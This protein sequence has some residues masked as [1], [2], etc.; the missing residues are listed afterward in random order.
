MEMWA[1]RVPLSPFA[2]VRRVGACLLV[3]SA[4]LAA[5]TS[6][7][8]GSAGLAGSNHRI[9]VRTDQV[10]QAFD[11]RLLG[12]NVP[13]WLLPQL[14]EDE[15]FRELVVASGTTM[16]RLPGGS[17]SNHYDWL[18]CELG[19]PQRC[20]WTWALRP[21][22]FLELLET[23]GL[24]AMWTVSINGTAEEAAAAVAFFNGTVDDDRPIGRDRNGRDWLTV[25]HWAQL[26]TDGGHPEPAPIQF[27]EVGNEV[28]GA[29]RTAGRGCASWGWE[30]VW[31]CDGA[32]YVNGTDGHDG[33]LQFREEMRAVDADIEV[34][35]VGVGDLGAW[36][37]WDNKVM[38]GAADNIDFYVVHQYG[39]N[40]DVPAEDVFGIP[41]REWP[42]ITGDIRDAYTDYGIAADV[43]IAATEHNLVAFLDGDDEQLMTRAVNA[44]YLAETIGQMA[45]SGVTIANQW[46]LANGRGANGTDYGLIDAQTHERSPAYYAMALWSRFGDELVGVDSDPG[47]NGLGLYGGRS[48]D[49][50]TQLLV[51]NPSATGFG[52]TIAVEPAAAPKVVTADVVV[53]DSLLATSVSWNGSPTPSIDLSELSKRLP[54]T[55][56]GELRHDFP[57]YSITL[58]SWGAQAES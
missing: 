20:Y 39:S 52:A 27:W 47:L 51:V 37:D 34:G 33:F 46:N 5:C 11:R 30:D 54:V 48:P 2:S 29:V 22:D 58:L 18:G 38:G 8:L 53:A 6:Q 35:A 24:P 9:V 55:A 45:T 41:R 4:L 31:T 17:W 40:G 26:R 12:T 19:D 16:L 7:E 32:E 25:G 28:Y 1:R 44:F 10:T 49:G 14:V 3:T 13:A 23:T 42:R 21:S 15:G 57:A 43:P 56:D 36:S 50:S